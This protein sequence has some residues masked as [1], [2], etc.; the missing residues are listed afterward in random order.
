LTLDFVLKRQ[1]GALRC[2]R[3]RCIGKNSRRNY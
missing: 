2:F 3:G 1:N